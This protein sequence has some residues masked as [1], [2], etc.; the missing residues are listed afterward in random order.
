MTG[1][2]IVLGLAGSGK[3]TQGKLLADSTGYKWLSTGVIL[4][5]NMSDEHKEEML[6][7]K[8]LDQQ[9]VIDILAPELNL[10]SDQTTEII[11]DGFPRGVEQ[12]QWLVD[13]RNNN[14]LVIESVIHILAHEKVVKERLLERGRQDDNEKAIDTSFDEYEHTIKPILD[15]FK[16][17][18]ASV[19]E[20]NGEQS[21]K[22]V[23]R[24]IVEKLISSGVVSV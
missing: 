8:V 9:E 1:L 6:A 2:I 3:S 20:I 22:A 19:V 14:L 16:S 15:L 24:Q 4:R 10:G 12:A 13:Q 11:L 18:G 23:H 5:K 17:A 7:G 21:I